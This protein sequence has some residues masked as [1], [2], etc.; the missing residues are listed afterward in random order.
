MSDMM[1]NWRYSSFFLREMGRKEG[2]KKGERK[3]RK[4]G[5]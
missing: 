1:N 2:R 5:S 4:P 3:K